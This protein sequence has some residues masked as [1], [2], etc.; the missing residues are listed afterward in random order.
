MSGSGSSSYYTSDS[1]GGSP[2]DD[3]LTLIERVYLSSPDA[4]VV[5]KIEPK[6][7]LEVSLTQSGTVTL[8]QAITEEGE[9]AGSLIPKSMAK[10]IRCITAEG[11]SYIAIVLEKHG[12]AV[13]LEIRPKP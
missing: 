4:A 11:V 7:I 9:I 13:Q 2:Q 5:A 8:L 6:T 1:D 10:L 12:G 3:C